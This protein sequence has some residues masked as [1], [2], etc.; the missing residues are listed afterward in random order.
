[1]LPGDI[2]NYVYV[3]YTMQVTIYALYGVT[4]ASK[5]TLR[6][7]SCS[8]SYNYSMWGRKRSTGFKYYP[9]QREYVEVSDT[10]FYQ[11]RLLELQCSLA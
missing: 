5:V 8:L 2:N 7:C 10:V 3:L 9:L 11:R 4:S 6:C 1:M